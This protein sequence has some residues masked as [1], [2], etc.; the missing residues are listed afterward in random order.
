MGQGHR[1]REVAWRTALAYA[2]LGSAWIL[3]SDG[4]LLFLGLDAATLAAVSK[5]KGLGFVLVTA[6]LLYLALSGQ[7]RQLM[8]AHEALETAES[9]Y[10]QLVASLP[11]GVMEFDDGGRIRYA[12]DAAVRVLGRVHGALEGQKLDSFAETTGEGHLYPARAQTASGSAAGISSREM[13]LLRPDGERLRVHLDWI[14]HRR[15]DGSPGYLGV[16]TDV[17]ELR[18]S[19]AARQRLVAVVEANPDLVLMN[20]RDGAVLHANEA[21]RNRL[22][23]GDGPD[24]RAAL[25]RVM[26]AWAW[27]RLRETAFA[28]AAAEGS[29]L[30]E[31]AFL[32]TEGREFPVSQLVIAHRDESRAITHFSSIV[33]DITAQKRADHALRTSREQYRSLVENANEG[34]VVAQHGAVRYANPR[35]L[36]LQGYELHD[37]LSRPWLDFVHP[38]DRE[39]VLDW[40]RRQ[41]RGDV[42]AMPYSFRLER[43]GGGVCWVEAST[44]SILWEGERATLTFFTDVTEQVEAQFRLDYL[45]EY[46]ELTG[47][48]NRRLFLGRLSHR[49]N[50][51]RRTGELLAVVYVDI[52]RMRLFN[53]SHGHEA[54]D[55]LIQAVA[56]RFSRLPDNQEL[57][58]RISS[59]EFAL[60]LSE[61]GGDGGT[62]QER[63]PGIL[64]IV[65]YPIDLDGTE[66]FMSASAG[67]SVYPAD[68]QDAGELLRNAASALDFARRMGPGTYQFYSERLDRKAAE[69]LRLEVDL[70]HALEEDAF[71]LYYQPQ[72]DL[73]T[74]AVI[75]A[76]ALLRW[77]RDGEAVLPGTFIPVLEES[78]LIGNVGA[79]VL[80]A[81]CRQQRRWDQHALGPLRLSVN[82][83]ARQL[84]DPRLPET[85]SRILQDTGADASRLEL[86]ITESALV[87]DPISAAETLERLKDLGFTIAIDDFGTGYSSLSNFRR[88]PVD[89]LKID[90]SFVLGIGVDGSSAEI[91]RAI[92]AMG[93]SLGKVVVAEGVETGEQLEVLRSHDCDR[94]QG[95]LLAKPLPATEFERQLQRGLGLSREDTPISGSAAF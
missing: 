72:A 62:I 94:I 67:I 27:Q 68:G 93:H 79:W 61:T 13:D 69:R 39:A 29:W 92:C 56:E 44:A 14:P 15:S 9:R 6:T 7:L 57:T 87:R 71:E 10:R 26:P 54:G 5:V 75:G 48:P 32:D 20:R 40:Y 59:D 50:R 4:L 74:G 43:K 52:N 78:S 33:R 65:G 66:C 47:L 31:N 8:Q 80:E 84:G 82:L 49:L 58:A 70:R 55:R 1:F 37:Y 2:L 86:E 34:L 41:A 24:D 17:T 45:A 91:A 76:E 90:K 23:L 16:L 88:F 89:V 83:S 64:E 25:A 46:D 28:S 11:Y 53:D 42:V 18:R 63:I 95:F 19:E 38:E 30:G 3:F 21:A 22:G 35:M 36:Q 12:N 81:A 60:V 85:V 51:A 73:R 77:N